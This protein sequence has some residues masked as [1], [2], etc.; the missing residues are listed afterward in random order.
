MAEVGKVGVDVVGSAGAGRGEAADE[1]GGVGEGQTGGIHTVVVAGGGSD[2]VDA[3]TELCHVEVGLEDAFLAPE[4]LDK[5][6]VVG[7]DN[8]PKIGAGAP[9][10]AVLGRLLREG[11]AAAKAG[12]LV[13]MADKHK[14]ELGEVEAVVAVEGAV[15]ASHD[16]GGH[17]WRD[18]LQGRPVDARPSVLVLQVAAQRH[19]GA[20]DRQ[21]RKGQYLQ[22]AP[23]H[24]CRGQVDEEEEQK[25]LHGWTIFL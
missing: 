9:G 14:A 7:F 23:Q 5:D 19:R 1:G 11:A 21:K 15:L 20:A 24:E 8:L 10:E 4:D 12:A 2:A 25:A 13:A 17:G 18:A 6:G 22:E 16:G 3:G